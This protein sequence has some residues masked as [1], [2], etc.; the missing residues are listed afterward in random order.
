MGINEDCI[1]YGECD[2]VTKDTDNNIVI[3]IKKKTKVDLLLKLLK[4]YEGKEVIIIV[5]PNRY[6]MNGFK[7]K[8]EKESIDGEGV[9]FTI[10][11][12]YC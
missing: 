12:T 4:S 3:G 11:D 10:G 6:I 2:Y 7:H 8:E 1:I 5:K 9:L